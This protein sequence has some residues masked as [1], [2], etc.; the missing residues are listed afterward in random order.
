[1][2]RKIVNIFFNALKVFF[3]IF[4]SIFT[5]FRQKVTRV[6]ISLRFVFYA[7]ISHVF[8]KNL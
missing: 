3:L 2:L 7:S 6:N 4:A 8:V 1:M 5:V